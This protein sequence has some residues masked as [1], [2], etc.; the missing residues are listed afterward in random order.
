MSESKFAGT[1][2]K[3]KKTK[4]K[5]TD[6]KPSISSSPTPTP[7]TGHHRGKRSDPEWANITILMRR[8][9]KRDVRRKLEDEGEGVDLSEIIDRLLTD[10]L[11]RPRG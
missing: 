6:P 2:S 8:S 7:L 10:W 3:L 5:P 4:E 11:S 9:I 1:L